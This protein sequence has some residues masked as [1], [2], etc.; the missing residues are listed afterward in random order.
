MCGKIKTSIVGR[1]VRD[2]LDSQ[3]VIGFGGYSTKQLTSSKDLS[4]TL[5]L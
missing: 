3:L 1:I 2:G 5:E 4:G